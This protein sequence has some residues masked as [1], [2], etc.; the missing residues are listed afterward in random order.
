MNQFTERYKTLSAA[1]LL[2]IIAT[3]NDYQPLAIEAAK[4]ELAARQLTSE[5]LSEANAENEAELQEKQ[6]KTEKRNAIENKVK[7][8]GT[9]LIDAVHPIQRTPPSA[10]R[11]IN[12]LSIVFGV[13]F[14]IGF[15]N[16]F[17]FI[18]FS[19]TNK[20]A[21]WSFQTIFYLLSTF[22]TPVAAYLF[23][24]RRRIGWIFFCAFF[25]Y[26]AVNAVSLL[27]ML[28]KHHDAIPA[29]DNF[30]PEV[31]PAA[32]LWNIFF[33]GGCLWLILKN[34]IKEIYTINKKTIYV[35]AGLGVLVALI[36]IVGTIG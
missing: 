25:S 31:S 27:F 12:I 21:K 10:N 15:F 20:A 22:F 17:D 24:G 26:S 1:A 4:D 11:T 32:P 14:L 3:P 16:Q 30:H 5:E 2:K 23:W 13:L 19:I 29:I 34:E 28:I 7:N 8:I 36:I 33:F 18:K 9:S 35:P 6:L